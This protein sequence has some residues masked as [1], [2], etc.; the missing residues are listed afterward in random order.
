MGNNKKNNKNNVSR[1]G[2]PVNNSP[3]ATADPEASSPLNA[4]EA[5][6]HPNTAINMKGGSR[7]NHKGS[8]R[9]NRKGSRKCM[10]RK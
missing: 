8:R 1:P 10:C 3:R 9:A 7:K 5:G 2:S 6:F 4:E